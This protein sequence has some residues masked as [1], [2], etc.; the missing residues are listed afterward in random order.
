M[1]RNAGKNKWLFV[2]LSVSFLFFATCKLELGESPIGPPIDTGEDADTSYSFDLSSSR[3]QLKADNIDSAKITAILRNSRGTAI[4]G[5]TITFSTNNVGVIIGASV[6]TDS[7]GTATTLLRS[8]QFNDTCVVIAVSQKTRNRDTVRIIFSG[9]K[10]SLK[11]NADRLKVNLYATIT[12]EITDGSDNPIDGDE[13]TFTVDGGTFS[14]NNASYS[15]QL[16]PDGQATVRVTT[17]TAGIVR[18]FASLPYRNLTDSR[19]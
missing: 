12:A 11:S 19:Y 4:V 8:T 14:D 6:V 10:M 17:Q 15:T 13:I 7:T 3:S 16:D 18:V 5:D 1:V 2:S 9:V